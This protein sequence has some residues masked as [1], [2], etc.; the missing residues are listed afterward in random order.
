MTLP[1]LLVAY[2]TGMAS[3]GL[4][5]VP[6]GIGVVETALVLALVADGAA[7][8]LPAVLLYRLIRLIGVVAAGWT[9]FAAQQSQHNPAAVDDAARSGHDA[10]DQR[11]V[12][13]PEGHRCGTVARC[14][15]LSRFGSC[16]VRA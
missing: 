1:L 14:A 2:T 9:V 13:S 10:R 5:R 16:W 8:A 4:S 7:A 11:S 15:R 12:I 6:G 3:S